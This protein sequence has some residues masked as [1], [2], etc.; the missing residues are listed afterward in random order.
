MPEAIRSSKSMSH[1]ASLVSNGVS[2][3]N[4]LD[5]VGILWVWLWWLDELESGSFSFVDSS[6]TFLCCPDFALSLKSS[7]LLDTPPLD[8][9]ST[10]VYESPTRSPRRG[11]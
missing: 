8:S 4:R 7:S 2:D 5:L 9:P 3:R 6:D 1:L 11:L 10:D